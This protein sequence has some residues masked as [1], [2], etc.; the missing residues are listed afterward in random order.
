MT[1]TFEIVGSLKVTHGDDAW[2][3]VGQVQIEAILLEPLFVLADEA[4]DERHPLFV[5]VLL[6]LFLFGSQTRQLSL[7]NTL[8]HKFRMKKFTKWLLSTG[9]SALS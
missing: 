8:C 3:D 9:G 5:F 7:P 1:K 4:F 6:L 2:S